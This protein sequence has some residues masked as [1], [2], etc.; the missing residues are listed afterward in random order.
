M[1]AY[2]KAAWGY[3]AQQL[4]C[5][6]TCSTHFKQNS[7]IAMPGQIRWKGDQNPPRLPYQRTTGCWN[8]CC[9]MKADPHIA[10][11]YFHARCEDRRLE[12]SIKTHI[13][14]SSRKENI[15]TQDVITYHS[16]TSMSGGG[17]VKI[18]LQG[19]PCLMLPPHQESHWSLC[20]WFVLGGKSMPGLL[21]LPVL[22]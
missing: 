5:C 10:S 21:L 15:H 16:P 22:L 20:S 4:L 18:F 1:T 19:L 3:Q 11:T 2:V 14:F 13:S 9:L 17:T 8:D 12:D 6:E 7:K